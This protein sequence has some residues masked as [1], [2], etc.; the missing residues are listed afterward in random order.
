[1]IRDPADLHEVAEQIAV[2]ENRVAKLQIRI[3][4]LHKEGSDASQAKEL[5]GLVRSNLVPGV[6]IH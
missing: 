4:Q 2:T 6:T 3:E 5:L 1:M